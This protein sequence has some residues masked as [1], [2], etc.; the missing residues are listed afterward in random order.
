ML[1][2]AVHKTLI[3]ILVTFSK[4]INPAP[5]LLILG[6]YL[7]ILNLGLG[8]FNRVSSLN[9]KGVDENLHASIQSVV[10]R[11][12]ATVLKLLTGKDQSLLIWGNA[13]LILNLSLD[14]FVAVRSFN[15]KNR[16]R[17]SVRGLQYASQQICILKRN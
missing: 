14:I 16:K 9:L 10:V 11:E 2:R 8:I 6:N 15:L 1:E 3:K 12:G 4:K 7:V 5:A 17:T 13:L